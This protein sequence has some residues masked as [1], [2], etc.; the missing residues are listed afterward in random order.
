MILQSPL[1]MDTLWGMTSPAPA[2]N[3]LR[4]GQDDDDDDD[5]GGGEEFVDEEDYVAEV[6]VQL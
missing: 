6:T 2:E 1:I 5:E 3:P 4:K